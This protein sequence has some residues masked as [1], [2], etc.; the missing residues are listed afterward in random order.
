[1]GTPLRIKLP[2]LF[3]VACAT[4]ILCL[5]A[6]YM[7][8]ELL[9]TGFIL[10]MTV[11][12]TYVVIGGKY[13][14]SDVSDEK[15]ADSCYYL[16]FIFTIASIIVS[17]IDLPNIQNDML[18]IATRFGVAMIS[19]IVGLTVRV[20]LVS[21]RPNI[22]DALRNNER[23]TIDAARRLTDEYVRASHA[24]MNFRGEV[25]AATT[26]AVKTVRDSFE[27]VAKDNAERMKAHFEDLSERSNAAFLEN[28]REIKKSSMSLNL[29]VDKY[30]RVTGESL[31]KLDQN[32]DHFTQSLLTRLEGV[33]FPDDLF[34]QKLAGPIVELN[35]S[36]EQVNAG[37]RAVTKDV[38][39]AAK[40]VER[41][42]TKIN[43][44]S[45]SL[46]AVLE[47]ATGISQE[48][49]RLIELV[50]ASH[51][52]ALKQSQHHDQSIAKLSQQQQ[53]VNERLDTQ[54]TNLNVMS[55]SANSMTESV[56]KLVEQIT[57]GQQATISI[58]QS[59]E[60]SHTDQQ[61]LIN[62]LRVT[63]EALP[64][65]VNNSRTQSE[66]LAAQIHEALQSNVSMTQQM[67]EAL[68][69]NQKSV[70]EALERVN[71]AGLSA[72][73]LNSK[74]D[75]PYASTQYINTKLD[76]VATA[77]VQFGLGEA[78]RPLRQVADET[79]ST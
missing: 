42:I 74:V 43:L 63:M 7:L 77:P 60:R 12:L 50:R 2:A 8:G 75:N 28:A 66:A 14:T 64:A 79:V 35:G 67:M 46:S 17:L 31:E 37:I 76:L 10:P 61:P 65:L 27:D 73:L 19:T 38:N 30:A 44:Q 40:A 23:S 34:S 25:M 57:Q 36:A 39:G 3:T 16:G 70:R 69:R 26:E 48:Q 68:E 45:E 58:S 49:A 13:R 59:V 20:V 72:E 53:S 41:S 6:S 52:L 47:M 15:F 21:F 51:D 4:K 78:P 33:A 22:E 1:M 71:T 56:S 5:V 54:I 18:T 9:I 32:V 29:V 24:L 11:M 62:A 55:K